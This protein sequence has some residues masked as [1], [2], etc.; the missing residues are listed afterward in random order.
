MNPMVRMLRVQPFKG[1][2]ITYQL[3]KL[4]L[5]VPYWI[6]LALPQSWRPRAAWSVSRTVKLKLIRQIAALSKK[7]V[8]YYSTFENPA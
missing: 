6:L 7:Y 3:L 5:L 8:S 2:Y 1:I 4:V